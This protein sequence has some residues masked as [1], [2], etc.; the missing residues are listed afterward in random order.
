MLIHCDYNILCF[1]FIYS[2][3]M[4]PLDYLRSNTCIIGSCQVIYSR[5]FEKYMDS[6]ET[7]S[8]HENVNYVNILRL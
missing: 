7:R 3:D 8:I 5:V 6:D 1:I 4:T 2:T